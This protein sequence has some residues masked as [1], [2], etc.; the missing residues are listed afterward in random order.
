MRR[1]DD[2]DDEN[3]EDEGR[4]AERKDDEDDAEEDNLL[5]L[6]D[7]LKLIRF[8]NKIRGSVY[9]LYLPSSSWTLLTKSM[10][11]DE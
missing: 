7:D 2:E 8:G 10:S 9:C 3:M 5:A 6:Q 1:K 11:W 4:Q